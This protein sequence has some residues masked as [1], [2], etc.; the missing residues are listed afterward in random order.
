MSDYTLAEVSLRLRSYV[1]FLK[2]QF[3]CI[4]Q[5]PLQR[6]VCQVSSWFLPFGNEKGTQHQELNQPNSLAT[7][8]T[9]LYHPWSACRRGLRTQAYFVLH[10]IDSLRTVNLFSICELIFRYAM[11]WFTDYGFIMKDCS[12]S[13]SFTLHSIWKIRGQDSKRINYPCN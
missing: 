7:T 2:K 10:L 11:Q 8:T 5:L 3:S 13:S 4:T 1:L 12:L 9:N 6:D